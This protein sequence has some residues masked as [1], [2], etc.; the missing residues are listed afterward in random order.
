VN[1]VAVV[2]TWHTGVTPSSTCLTS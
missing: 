2:T 1:M